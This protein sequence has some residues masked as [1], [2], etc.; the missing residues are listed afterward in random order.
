MA[1]AAWAATP[2]TIRSSSSAKT[3]ASG[4]P[5][6]SPPRLSPVREMTGTAR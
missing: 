6:K 4:W 2:T 3:P 5:K 1:T